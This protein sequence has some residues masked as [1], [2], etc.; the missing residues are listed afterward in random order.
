M[1]SDKRGDCAY[2]PEVE[3]KGA[4]AVTKAS[5][6]SGHPCARVPARGKPN[7][8]DTTEACSWFNCSLSQ[9]ERKN[10]HRQG[11]P[12]LQRR[13]APT[14]QGGSIFISPGACIVLHPFKPSAVC[15]LQSRK[16]AS[17]EVQ[18]LGTLSI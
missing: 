12:A 6:C 17:I 15:H 18:L 2:S 16:P 7:L 1:H 9:R 14:M 3:G 4:V 8:S 11:T 13:F 5:S 10:P